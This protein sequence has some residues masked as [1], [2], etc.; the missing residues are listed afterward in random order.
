[1]SSADGSTALALALRE[2]LTDALRDPAVLEEFRAVVREELDAREAPLPQEADDRLMTVADVAR[3]AGVKTATVR[4]WLR[5]GKL[6]SVRAGRQW[7][8]RRAELDRFLAGAGQGEAVDVEAEAA[9][10]VA[11]ASR[12]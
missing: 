3:Y 1:M 5:A 4:G 7:R 8:M 6:P 11:M 2:L 10:I 9:R 12:R